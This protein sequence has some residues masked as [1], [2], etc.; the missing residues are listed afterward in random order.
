ME[1]QTYPESFYNNDGLRLSNF[2]IAGRNILEKYKDFL[3]KD[4]PIILK[5]KSKLGIN[6]HVSILEFSAPDNVLYVNDN[7]FD[8][9]CIN[10]GDVVQGELFDPPDATKVIFKPSNKSFYKIEDVKSILENSIIKKYQF[11]I[12][13]QIISINYFDSIIKLEVSVLEPYDICRTTEIDLNVDFLPIE[14]NINQSNNSKNIDQLPESIEFNKSNFNFR[15]ESNT[16]LNLNQ[17]TNRVNSDNLN[18][19]SNP[20]RE[21]LRKRRLSFFEKKFMK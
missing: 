12:K 2:A 16:S 4:K 15:E 5:L 21:D 11:L 1:L 6:F 14:D 20:S 17:V 8:Q 19:S 3:S 9:L 10:T 7:A 18:L 13:G